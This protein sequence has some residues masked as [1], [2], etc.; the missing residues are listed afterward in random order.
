MSRTPIAD[1]ALLSDR[2]S[3]ALV[4]AA[5]SVEWLSFPRFD[6]PSV[7]GRLL[8]D[9][10]GHWQVQPAGDVDEHPPLRR[11]DAGAG[12]DV[13]RPRTGDRWCS[14]TRWRSGPDNGGHRLGT[15][16]PHLLVRRLACTAGEVEVDGRLPRRGRSTAWSCRCSSPVDGG[17]TARGGA[18]WLV[19]TTPVP[20][21][22]ATRGT[23]HGTADAARRR[24]AC[25]WRCTA[26]TLEQTPARV[27]SQD[28]LAARAGRARSTAWR[29]WSALHQAYDGPWARPG[30]PQRPGAAGAVLPAQRR[31]RRRR[32]HLAARGRRRR[33]QLGLPLLLGA[34][35]QLHHGGAVGRRLPGRG[36]RL[37][38]VHDHRGRVR[39]SARATACRSCSAS[40][41]STTSPSASCRTCAGWRDSR[42]VRVGNGAWDQQPDRRVR[43]AARRR[44]SAG[45]PARRRSTTTP[46]GS[47]SPAPT[48]RPRAGRRRT[49]ASGRCAA[50]RSTSSTPRSC[51]GSRWTG[52]SRWPTCC[53]AER[54]GRRLEAAAR[55]DLRDRRPRRAGATR[56]ARS[57]S[58]FGSTALDASNLMMPIVGF[59][60]ADDPR[61]LATIDAI[62]AAAHRRAR[63][64][65]PL[66]HR[67]G[68]RR[69]RR[70]GGH[71]PALH[72]L[73][74]PGAGPGRPGRP[75]HARCSSGPPRSSTTSA[76]WPRRSTRRPASCSA[77]S[78]RRSATSAWST[79][80]GRSP[81]PARARPTA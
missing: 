38:R 59:L 49:R 30:A 81:R 41:A 64:G 39:R 6:S 48:P 53:G 67:G 25:T 73:A 60:P 16:V 71:L 43:R 65:L 31:D 77:T 69:P 74:G 15:D 24:D 51:A 3:S 63:A 52:R 21:R 26:R 8:G 23:A 54:P 9:D 32:D 42:P 36:R 29:S 14:P 35:R 79:P 4:T 58:T 33:T 66:P 37:L 34:R 27:W 45:R 1:H 22:P 20:A 72:V 46:G 80:P 7:F 50:S 62:D 70:R 68:R 13:H 17:V 55:R 61:M 2:H 78:R 12:D 11:P 5:G 40:A 10:A 57:P 56:P 18:E 44:R 75:G 47:W 76:C 19:L 28:E